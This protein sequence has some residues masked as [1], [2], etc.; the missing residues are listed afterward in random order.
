VPIFRQQAMGNVE[1]IKAPYGARNGVIM[2]N[3]EFRL[4]NWAVGSRGPEIIILT[5]MLGAHIRTNLVFR[6]AKITILLICDRGLT[7]PWTPHY[8]AIGQKKWRLDGARDE[9]IM[10][11]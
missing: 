9:L 2:N 6:P 7:D 8:G 3:Y 10:I 1:K 5:K 11:N 4:N